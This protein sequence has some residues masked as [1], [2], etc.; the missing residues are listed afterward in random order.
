MPTST[1]ALAIADDLTGAF[2]VGAIL[3]GMG[4]RSLVT[5]DEEHAPVDGGV[6]VVDSETRHA[7]PRQAREW[8][9]RVAARWAG[10]IFKKT[11]STLRGNIGAE[12]SGLIEA[13]GRKLVYLPAYP[14]LGRTV[15]G[16][17]LY[18]DGVPIAATAFARDARN[19]VT[20]S[21]VVRLMQRDC[22]FPI[23]VR[24]GVTERD[25]A[26][27]DTEALVASPAGFTAHWAARM[28]RKSVAPLPSVGSFRILCGSLHA[29]S[30]DQAEEARQLGWDVL[31]TGEFEPGERERAA[32]RLAAAALERSPVDALVIF[33]GDTAH[34]VLTLLGC[35]DVEPLGEVEPGVPV[36]RVGTQIVITKAG[37]FGSPGLAARI[38]A[39]LEKAS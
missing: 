36:S 21:S 12:F 32:A 3:A 33:G 1:E 4:V 16:G 18:V 19:P 31:T 37:G 15:V 30:R 8:H 23:D 13:T 29:R 39:K 2:E 11:D 7:T 10:P 25:F 38:R 27:V 35:R 28:P 14:K 6:L 26:G 24:D 17:V 20:E 5:L 34:A 9:R 22:A